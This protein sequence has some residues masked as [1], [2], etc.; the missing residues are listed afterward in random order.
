M[1]YGDGRL[2]THCSKVAMNTKDIS[3]NPLEFVF[4]A[5]DGK[6]GAIIMS[7]PAHAYISI[8]R[9]FMRVPQK[10]PERSKEINTISGLITVGATIA[11]QG[12][13]PERERLRIQRDINGILRY[14]QTI[15]SDEKWEDDIDPVFSLSYNMLVKKQATKQDVASLSTEIVG[16]AEVGSVDAWRKRIDRWAA[17]RKLPPIGQPKRPS[18]RAN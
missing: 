8:A 9:A 18:R 16:A 14:F 3:D 15:V 6:G 13:V 1:W 10:E 5:P 2:L 7:M 12:S 4:L 11:T 17:A